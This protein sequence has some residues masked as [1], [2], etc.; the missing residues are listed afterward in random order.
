M[1]RPTYGP[2]RN[3]QVVCSVSPAFVSLFV[4]S[5]RAFFSGLHKILPLNCVNFHSRF[6]FRC[7][8]FI[9]YFS[10]QSRSIVSLTHR[11]GLNDKQCFIILFV[12]FSYFSPN[13]LFLLPLSPSSNDYQPFFSSSLPPFPSPDPLCNREF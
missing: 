10:M 5:Y 4:K 3:A 8:Y 12:S 11:H 2:A 9:I 6:L 7:L 13:P 1:C